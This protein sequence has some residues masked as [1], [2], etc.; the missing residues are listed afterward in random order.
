MV[1]LRDI[2]FD[3]VYSI[4]K[5]TPAN[6]QQYFVSSAAEMIAMAFAGSNEKCPGFLAAIYNDEIPVGII[7]IGRSEVENGE[8]DIL[9]KYKY[10]YRL[11]GFFID[12]NYQRKGIGK[13]ALKL[14]FDKLKEYPD[15]KQLP[16]YL[17]CKRENKIALNLYESFGFKNTGILYE[18]DYLLVKFPE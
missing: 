10:A 5:L 16:L 12:E 9:Q 17:E 14:A 15:S 2:M 3:N 13:A 1:E 18:D 7:L 11:W 6:N 4:L 8:V